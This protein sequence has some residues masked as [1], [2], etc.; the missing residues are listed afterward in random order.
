LADVSE[1][2]PA[3]IIREIT[4]MME[5]AS[6]SETTV[7]LYQTTRRNSPEDSHFHT[8]RH[9]NLNLKNTTVNLM[10]KGL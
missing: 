2:F 1:E 7:F 6:T 5:A 8:R 4:P 3:S 10:M 9:E